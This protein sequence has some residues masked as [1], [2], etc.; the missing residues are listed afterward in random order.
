MISF[1]PWRRTMKDK[2]MTPY[3]LTVKYGICKRTV[4]KFKNNQNVTLETL[5]RMCN[6]LDCRIEDIVE[7]KKT[8][9]KKNRQGIP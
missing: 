6:I 7:F 8:H 5:E 4:D 2:Q 9:P 3:A 1:D